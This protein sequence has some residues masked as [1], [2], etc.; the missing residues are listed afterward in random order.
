MVP[1]LRVVVEHPQRF[2]GHSQAVSRVYSIIWKRP[3]LDLKELARL[4]WI[5][6][7]SVARLAAHFGRRPDTTI[8]GCLCRI[9][10]AGEWRSL[11]FPQE[12]L[13]AIRK[14]TEKVFKGVQI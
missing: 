8:Q 9:R 2:V 7:W 13:L 11:D 4:R 10:K 5:H 3:D 1:S 14:N 6:K 12:E